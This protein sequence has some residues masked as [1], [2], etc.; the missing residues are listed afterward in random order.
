MREWQP[1]LRIADGSRQ[2]FKFGQ[3]LFGH[4]IEFL[5]RHHVE[6]K[7]GNHQLD[8]VIVIGGHDEQFDRQQQFGHDIELFERHSVEF[9]Q[10]FV[11]ERQQLLGHDIKLFERHGI[12]LKLGDFRFDEFIVIGRH[13]GQQQFGRSAARGR[14]CLRRIARSDIDQRADRR[15]LCHGD[16]VG[17]RG[18]RSL[19]LELQ[20]QQWR[21]HHAMLGDQGRRLRLDIQFQ[22]FRRFHKLE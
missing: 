1:A 13:G 4:D 11:I 7:L 6:L 10:L 15:S 21:R 2:Q 14:R 16:P 12:K 18:L 17:G 5:E 8:R 22:F 20:R 3:Q 19:D 9:N